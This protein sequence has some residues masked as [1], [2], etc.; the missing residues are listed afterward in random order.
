MSAARDPLR[1]RQNEPL[2]GQTVQPEIANLIRLAKEAIVVQKLDGTIIGWNPAAE[3]IFGFSAAEIIGQSISKLMPPDEPDQLS[4]ITARIRQ[5]STISDFQTRRLRKDRRAVDVSLTLFPIRGELGDVLGVLCLATDISEHKRLERSERDQLFLSAIV[6]S[7]EDAIISKNLN[8]IV[9]S[10]NPGAEKLYGYTSEEMIGKPISILI[11]A[12]HQD[13]E[14]QIL[15]RIRRGEE[16]EHYQTQRVRK[17]GQLV[18]VSLTVSPIRDSLG[19]IIGAS[20]IARDVT[21]SKLAESRQRE[22][23]REAQDARSEAERAREQA[24]AASRAK[25]EFLVNISHELRTPLTSILGWTQMLM[26]HRLGPER[27]QK[28]IETIDRQARS[29]AQLIEDLL[30]VSRIISGR[31]RVDFKPVDLKAIVGM[32]LEAVRPGA[33]AKRIH[34]QSTF[35]SGA[36]PVVGDAERLQQVVWNLLSN[37]VKFTAT[38]GTVQ[39]EVRRVASQV[40]LLVRDNGIGIKPAFLPHLFE[41]FSQADASI[42]RISSGLGMGLSIVKSLVE[43]HGGVVFASSPGEGQGTTFIVKLP[44][45]EVR[46]DAF[47]PRPAEE[48]V[49]QPPLQQ[50]DDLRGLRILVVDDQRDTSEMLEFAFNDC[51]AIVQT[52]QSAEAAL[53]I[54]DKWQPDMLVSDV[55]MPNVDGYELIRIIREERGSEIPAIALTAMARVQ[56]RLKALTAGYQ[57]HVAKPV[58]PGELIT[59]ASGLV[60]LVNRRSE[61]P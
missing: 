47:R 23:L 25:D 57:M 28:A 20:K 30:D 18:D 24:E 4:R 33:E 7:A 56:D 19:Q 1:P 39:V 44:I 51:G 11:P 49:A 55:G 59:I 26:S 42:T 53:A 5:G 37:A 31:L 15:D 9:T 27:Q 43:L 50:R 16:I 52:A 3:H 54:F 38:G 36:G 46:E 60:G 6:S 17:D 48:P 35:S 2:D 21:Q 10:W 58:E 8:G 61:P 40:E 12:D 22:F 34:L 13:E 41:R 14:P 29:Q 45:S 32:A